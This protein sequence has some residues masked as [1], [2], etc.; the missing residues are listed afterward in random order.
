M[1]GSLIYTGPSLLDDAPIFVAAVWASHPSLA[2]SK[3]GD[4]VQTYIMRSDMEPMEASRRGKDYSVCGDCRHRGTP[5]YDDRGVAAKRSCYVQ[6]GRGPAMVYSAWQRG[7]Y[8]EAL[9]P[10]ARAG[11]GRGRVVRIGAYGDGA[12]VPAHVWTD[13]LSEAKGHTAYS[14]LHTAANPMGLGRANSFDPA[15][16]MA[17]VDSLP[18]AQAAWSSGYR[19]FRVVNSLRQMTANEIE[20]PA[21][22]VACDKCQL[23][24]GQHPTAK[25]IAVVV[26]GSGKKHFGGKA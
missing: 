13:L 17:S 22:R 6:L 25:S 8:H 26:H 1:P 14:H 19:T 21:E 9:T 7:N 5:T 12:A 23:C 24:N 3:T 10:E 15:L 18:E 4:L 16:Y 2:N 20:C 11:V